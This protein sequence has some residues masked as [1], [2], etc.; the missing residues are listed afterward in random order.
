M[1]AWQVMNYSHRNNGML[2]ESIEVLG[3]VPVDSVNGLPFEYRH[4]NLEFD[5]LDD[6]EKMRFSGFWIAPADPDTEW[7]RP[8]ICVPLE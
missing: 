2:P 8:S 1:L 5:K 6:N 4:G 7:Q 3:E